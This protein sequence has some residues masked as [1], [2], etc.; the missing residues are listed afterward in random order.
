MVECEV[1]SHILQFRMFPF[2]ITI[3][4]YMMVCIFYLLL[5]CKENENILGKKVYLICMV[6]VH[7]DAEFHVA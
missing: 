2:V 6:D 4:I 7:H 3:F 1:F 5:F